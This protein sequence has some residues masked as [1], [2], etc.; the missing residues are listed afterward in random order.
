MDE[1]RG[2]RRELDEVE[3]RLEAGAVEDWNDRAR[4]D[5]RRLLE[6]GA[7]EGPVH[8][9]RLTSRTAPVSSPRWRS[10]SAGQG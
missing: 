7:S 6:A 9:L 4:E 5:R 2:F 8:E 10:S 3:R 1:I